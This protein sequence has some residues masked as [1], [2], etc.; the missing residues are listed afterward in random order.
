M[1]HELWYSVVVRD[2]HGK[3]LSRERRRSRSFLKAWNQIVCAQM[4]AGGVLSVL[5]TSGVSRNISDGDTSFK[6]N[7]AGAGTDWGLRVGTGNTPVAIDDYALETPI[8]QGT[9]AGQ[10]EHQVCTVATSV[11]SAPSCYFV[12]S[13]TITNN[14]GD[15]ITV[16]EAALYMQNATMEFCGTRDVFGAPQVVPDGGSVTVDWTIQVTV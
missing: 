13:R 4:K 10:M 8:A 11:V 7:Q 14:S 15:S 5:D 2:R 9:A 16:R 1:K 6:M 12:V 3:V